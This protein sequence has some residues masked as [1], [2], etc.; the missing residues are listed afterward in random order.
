MCFRTWPGRLAMLAGTEPSTAAPRPLEEVALAWLE[1]DGRA[2]L[3]LDSEL[4]VIWRNSAAANMLRQYRGTEINRD[5]VAHGDLHDQLKKFLDERA[6]PKWERLLPLA[7][8]DGFYIV[9]AL[10][11][12]T[13]SDLVCLEIRVAHPEARIDYVD[14]REPF[15]LTVTENRIALLLLDGLSV[16]EIAKSRGAS[17]ETVRSHVRAIYEKT[18]SSSREVLFSRL[19]HFQAI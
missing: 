7:T 4:R 10:R 12:G 19:R 9:R 8:E 17:V 6:A 11:I 15:G 1:L 13:V 18:G 5:Q 3:I 16:T 2:R 14:L